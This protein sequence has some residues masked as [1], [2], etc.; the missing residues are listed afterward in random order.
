MLTWKMSEKTTSG[1]N[2]HYREVRTDPFDTKQ[3]L[4]NT[5]V[6]LSHRF[7]Y[8]F[9]SSFRLTRTAVTEKEQPD[10]VGRSFSASLTANLQLRRQG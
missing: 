10:W 9:N 7:N 4:L 2:V 5:G 1:Y 8:L 6:S 3:T